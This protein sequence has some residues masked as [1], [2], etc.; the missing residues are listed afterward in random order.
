MAVEQDAV[1][2]SKIKKN[3]KLTHASDGV[4]YM[5]DILIPFKGRKK[6]SSTQRIR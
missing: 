4:D 6:S 5:T 3:P 2:F 1:D